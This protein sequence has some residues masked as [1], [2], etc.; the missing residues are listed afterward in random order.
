MDMP[1][2]LVNAIPVQAIAKPAQQMTWA[3]EQNGGNAV[4]LMLID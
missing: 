1:H 2:A 3:S 4:N